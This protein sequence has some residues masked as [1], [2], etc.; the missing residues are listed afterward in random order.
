[1]TGIGERWPPAA[2]SETDQ[3]ALESM[4]KKLL[5]LLKEFKIHYGTQVQINNAGIHTVW[6]L[7]DY[8]TDKADCRAQSPAQ[9]GFE[10]GKAGLTLNPASNWDAHNARINA[11]RL[12]NAAEEALARAKLYREALR[13]TTRGPSSASAVAEAADRLALE[14]AYVQRFGG[15]KPRIEDQLAQTALGQ[16]FKDLSQGRLGFMP[17]KKMVPLTEDPDIVILEGRRT[18][19]ADGTSR[20][21]DNDTIQEPALM[22][23]LRRTWRRFQTNFLMCVAGLPHVDNVQ[24]TK[25][26]MLDLYEFIDGP[27]LARQQPPPR[28]ATMRTAERAAWRHLEARVH[29]GFK[30][31]EEM[32][33]LP[34]D[35]TLWQVEVYSKERSYQAGPSSGGLPTSTSPDADAWYWYQKGQQKAQKGTKNRNDTF[36]PVGKGDLNTAR[37]DAAPYQSKGE[38]KNKGGKQKKGDKGGKTPLDP[39]AAS[40][41]FDDGTFAKTDSRGKPYCTLH[42]QGKC[43]F[44]CG[45]NHQCPKVLQSTGAPCN[46]SHYG[47]RCWNT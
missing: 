7:G 42:Q 39:A 23:A 13:G 37:Y 21:G 29:Q 33:K 1:M 27:R 36:G 10:G 45:Q 16:Q 35:P 19:T 31:A 41:A 22:E 12:S 2:P 47:L 43:N 28:V 38:S 18:A 5:G 17:I 34:F 9:L 4:D 32:Q 8:W 11:V 40:K 44:K 25:Q 26:D 46:G 20:D 3:T 15:S 14:V 24:I 30:L 6:E